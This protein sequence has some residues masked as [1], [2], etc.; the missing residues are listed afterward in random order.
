[1]MEQI[2]T[3]AS[4]IT[5]LVI[6]V[7]ELI[8]TQVNNYK[9]LPVINVIAGIFLGVLYALSFL[10]DAVVLYA[11]AGAVSGLAAGGLFDLGV[12]VIKKEK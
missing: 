7:T 4:I 5:P 2:L 11:W 10:Q 9:I 6:A 12:S 8:K 3:A 1:M